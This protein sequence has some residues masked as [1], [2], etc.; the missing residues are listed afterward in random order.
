MK[1]VSIALII[2]GGALVYFAIHA[3]PAPNT[4]SS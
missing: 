1:L 4:A 2:A 3:A